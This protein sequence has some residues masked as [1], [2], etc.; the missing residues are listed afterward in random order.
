MLPDDPDA[1]A[2]FFYLS[3]LGLAWLLKGWLLAGAPPPV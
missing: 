3:L 2:R 1:Q